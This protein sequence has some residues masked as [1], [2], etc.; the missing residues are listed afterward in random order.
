MRAFCQESLTVEHCG[1]RYT[2]SQPTV[3]AVH[4]AVI[5]YWPEILAALKLHSSE[6]PDPV[7]T[8]LPLFTRIGRERL[9]MV[10]LGCVVPEQGRPGQMAMDIVRDEKLAR[11]LIQ[12]LINCCNIR[13]VISTLDFSALQ[14]DPDG[15]TAEDVPGLI[16]EQRFTIMELALIFHQP[17]HS[18]MQ[19]SYEAFIQTIE[20]IPQ[21]LDKKKRVPDPSKEHNW[22][23]GSTLP[24]I[25]VQKVG[26]E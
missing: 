4:R 17:P 21:V 19:W 8:L 14:E 2:L 9:S 23:M 6:D 25:V 24:G 22:F 18:I 11:L 15:F 10:L 16:P 13:S 5:L 1:L 7:K 26:A 3:Q 12:A 20:A